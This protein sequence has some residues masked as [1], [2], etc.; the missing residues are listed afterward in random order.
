MSPPARLS[1]RE[2]TDALAVLPEWSHVDNALVRNFTFTTFADGLRFVASVG[3]LAEAMN[4]HP[5]ID[6]RFRQV[7]VRCTTH[8]VGGVTQLDCA[9]A[10]AC[11]E[12]AG[13]R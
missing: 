11:D 6:I 5:D 8:D 1:S 7:R 4:H 9:L 3:T 12:Q 13:E 10:R 2:I